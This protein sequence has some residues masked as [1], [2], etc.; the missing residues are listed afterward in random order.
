MTAIIRLVIFAV[1]A[2]VA[3]AAAYYGEPLVRHSTDAITILTTV[4]TVFAGF[5]VA[6]IVL[7]GDPAL[8]PDGSW[9]TAEVRRESVE[10]QLILHGWLF[11][12]Y[13]LAIGLLFVGVVV[14][15]AHGVP[16]IV[17]VWISRAYLFLGVSSF[18]FTFGLAKSMLA[19][20]M[21]R[22]DSEIKK[23]RAAAGLRD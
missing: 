4:F 9:R 16:E 1:C 7:L 12:S 21:A 14:S 20:Q 17:K 13:L 23:R 22:F 8:I 6:V 19:Y 3:A 11:I 2:A 10:A 5:L 18:L 15:E